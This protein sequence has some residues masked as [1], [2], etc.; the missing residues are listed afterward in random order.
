MAIR[1]Q[2]EDQLVLCGSHTASLAPKIVEADPHWRL[3]F[4]MTLAL[5]RGP[6]SMIWPDQGYILNSNTPLS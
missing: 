6:L 3:R 4:E 5:L 2:R 1:R